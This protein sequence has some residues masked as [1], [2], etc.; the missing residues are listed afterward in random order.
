MA[1]IDDASFHTATLT[2]TT[3]KPTPIRRWE[4]RYSG[5]LC[6]VDALVAL[7]AAGA[8]FGFRFGNVTDRSGKYLI[9]SLALPVAWVAAAALA[10]AYEPRFLFVG[11]EERQRVLLAG[12]GLIA[13]L[14]I[15]SYAGKFEVARGYVVI[16]L[17]GTTLAVLV[18]RHLA[19][20]WVHRQRR[21]G[22]FMQRVL[23]VGYER[24]VAELA[25]QLNRERYHGMRVVGACL[26]SGYSEGTTAA[27][28]GVAVYGTFDD[29]DAAVP[30]AEADTVA[31]LSTP[32]WD[33]VALR[34]LA[35]KLEK[36]RV[37][38]I[39]APALLDVAGPR[40]TI[41]PVDGL[42]LLHV[43][44]PT[45]RGA[46]R[47]AKE[48]FDRTVSA[49]ALILLAPLLLG[50]AVAIR[51]TSS[52]PALFRQIRVGKDGSTFQVLKFRSMYSDAETRLAELAV[53]NEHD[54]V[55][56]KMRHD[57]RITSAGRW[58]R[59]Y[60]LDELPQLINVLAGQM[61]L[62]GPRPPLPA[63]V[64]RYADDVRRR[65]V[66]KPGLTGLWQVSGRS[67]LSWDE[68]VRLDLRYVENW[69]LALD[70]TI[71][72]R[73]IFAVLGSRGAY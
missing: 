30:L 60:S 55:L 44:H 43:E 69:S 12:A 67:D 10:R 73:T 2:V 22:R 23:L 6:A 56:F 72:W 20:R 14:A 59:K 31:V 35:W 40:T 58:L 37:D 70:I 39:V 71:M 47:V 13:A 25:R 32:E 5:A 26:P 27:D 66:V 28:L 53:Q 42:P 57:P 18:A 3:P 11:P 34:R 33:G 7:L 19:R 54:G 24:G 63:E 45:L 48:L 9:F 68:S 15:V 21:G 1:I 17:P 8:A 46:R 36:R 29:V 16:A 52:G 38:M 41:R 65:L 4:R 61:S 50:I 49:G 64:D 51:L 62:V